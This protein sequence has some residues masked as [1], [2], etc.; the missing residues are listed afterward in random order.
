MLSTYHHVGPAYCECTDVSLHEG[1]QTYKVQM[2]DLPSNKSASSFSW[3]LSGLV[4]LTHTGSDFSFL[5]PL[6]HVRSGDLI[7]VLL[8]CVS[9]KS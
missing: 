1:M 6:N 2:L 4:Q 8:L 5:R 9:I 3:Y 7:R